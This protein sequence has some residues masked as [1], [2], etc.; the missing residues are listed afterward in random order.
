L[1]ATMR[2]DSFQLKDSR[3]T[4]SICRTAVRFIRA[5]IRH[6]PCAKTAI[7]RSCGFP[8]RTVRRAGSMH[9]KTAERLPQRTRQN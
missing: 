9:K 3:R 8:I 5:V 6:C 2:T 1:T 4:S 7:R